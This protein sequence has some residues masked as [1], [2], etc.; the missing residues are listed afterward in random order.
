MD[1]YNRDDCENLLERDGSGVIEKNVSALLPEQ[2]EQFGCKTL[3]CHYEGI[4][5]LHFTWIT[6]IPDNAN[7]NN[8][9]NQ[10]SILSDFCSRT[11]RNTVLWVNGN[12]LWA[13]L[14]SNNMIQHSNILF[15]LN[16][17]FLRRL[18]LCLELP[19]YFFGPSHNERLW[20]LCAC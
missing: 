20:W 2:E 11:K 13:P 14:W 9:F 10:R 18:I 6:T 3:I 8:P 16:D 1:W 19:Q 17:F 12:H 5:S 7:Y 15:Q 4:V